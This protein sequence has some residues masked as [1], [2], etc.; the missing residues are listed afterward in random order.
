[1]RMKRQAGFTLIEIAM[2]MLIIGLVLSTVVGM[3]VALIKSS[4]ITATKQRMDLA[5]TA[6]INFIAHNNRLPCPAVPTLPPLTAGL[7][8]PGYGAEAVTSLPGVLPVVCNVAL[9]NVVVAPVFTGILPWASLG[10]TDE[11]AADG[12]YNRFT[13]RVA[14]S[15][16]VTISA[17]TVAGLRG[18]ITVHS[19][20]PATM[21]AAPIGNQTNNCTPAG[22]A[23]NPCA[24]VALIMS[25]GANGF[26]AY[27][28]SGGMMTASTGA[29]EIQNA[30][31]SSAFVMR[32]FSDAPLN[33]FDDIVMP[34]TAN[35][36]LAQLTT[37]GVLKDANAVLNANFTNITAIVV[38]D[39]IANRSLGL[40]AT[41]TYPLPSANTFDPAVPVTP[42]FIPDATLRDPWSNKIVYTACVPGAAGV[43]M[44]NNVN[45]ALCLNARPPM[46]IASSSIPGLIA[47]TLTSLGPDGILNGAPPVGDDIVF[48][49][50]VNQLQ[51]SFAV[52][53]W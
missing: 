28:N 53:G 18:S 21:G 41:R 5:K 29:D 51:Q 9:A 31:G 36:L 33:P 50:Y 37:T 44:L 14:Q 25:H 47:F 48:T 22:Q 8:T 35:N 15:A 17:Q 46:S 23:V 42:P 16:T 12:Y 24:A 1:M 10:L 7:P 6:L 52:V 11:N 43:V 26:G 32:D 38:A 3:S 4:R 13:Y 20:A 40:P 49:V 27:T 19:T 39:A 34:L 2:V 30:N 45:A